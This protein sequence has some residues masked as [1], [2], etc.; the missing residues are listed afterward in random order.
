M[1]RV[2]RKVVIKEKE[3]INTLPERIYHTAIY[4]RLSVEDNS[5]TNEKES[6][7]M[8]Q[9]MLET[10]VA[11]Q[12]DMKLYGIFCDNGETGT[13][14]ERS[15]FE[16]MME[17]IRQRNVDCIVVKDL[18]RF[19]RNYIEVGYYLEK[20]FPYLGIRFIAVNDQYDTLDKQNNNEL[21]LS[22]KNLVNDLYA[23]DISQKINSAIL[24][25]QKKGEFIGALPPYGYLKSPE[26]KHKLIID[27]ETAPVVRDIFQWRLEGMGLMQIARRLN[28]R[29]IPCPAMY[30]YQKGHRKKQPSGKGTI[31]KAHGIKTLLQNPV[32]VGHMAQGKFKKS[33]SDGIPN[34][35]VKREDWIVVKN[36]HKAIIDPN[37]FYKVQEITK[38]RQKE[39]QAKQGK[40][41]TTEN[42][43]KGLLVC[44]DC[45]TKMIRYKKVYSSGKAR[46]TFLCRIYRENLNGQGC[47]AKTIGEP[48]LK[49]CITQTLCIQIA[50][51][52]NLEKLLKQLQEQ[53]KPQKQYRE[54]SK[55]IHQI[56]Q[57]IKRNR[58]KR[59]TLFE[60][61]SNHIISEADYWITK[62]R[63]EEETKKLE[64]QL[65]KLE[66]KEQ[67]V[68]YPISRQEEWIG[69]LKK[70]QSEEV[71]DREML[72]ELI[73][74]I[75]VYGS[76]EIEI[77]WNFQDEF[78]NLVR[79]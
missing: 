17:E 20:I 45:E 30:H 67:T 38:Q 77:I 31:W 7:A 25:K 1:A 79:T 56:Q 53:I 62:A 27:R 42:L 52:I 60:D 37:T 78:F 21:V 70:H 73:Q 26:D 3:P 50:L 71:I 63:Y 76:N 58:T 74:S 39:S 13:D 59:K 55:Q 29:K 32:Y 72:M 54:P 36:T 8:Q 18:S 2:S 47:T 22:L 33:L 12:S 57:K 11:A 16:H 10:Y 9:Y 35:A 23:K 19:G 61:Y 44:A 28:N 64:D 40:Y 34:T 43:L 15:G 75:R 6:I 5:H 49:E 65:S 4:I 14:F 48:E 41:S 24:T 68:S 46:Y 51:S 66:Q 69:A